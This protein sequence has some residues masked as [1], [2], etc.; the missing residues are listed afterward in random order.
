MNHVRAIKR[1]CDAKHW[2]LD[3]MK[4]ACIGGTTKILANELKLVFGN[5]IYIPDNPEFANAVGFLKLLYTKRTGKLLTE[6]EQG[7]EKSKDKEAK[8]VA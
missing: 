8:N 6:K 7:S 5:E 4:I 1:E 3:F 2:S